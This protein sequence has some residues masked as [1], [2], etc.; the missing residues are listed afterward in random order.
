MLCMLFGMIVLLLFIS[1]VL[2]FSPDVDSDA[3]ALA[4]II[5]ICFTIPFSY[6]FYKIATEKPSEKDKAYRTRKNQRERKIEKEYGIID[7]SEKKK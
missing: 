3:R 1:P 7:F 4:I 2:I 5:T 6:I